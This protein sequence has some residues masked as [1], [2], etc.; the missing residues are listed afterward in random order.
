[1]AA[2]GERGGLFGFSPVVLVLIALMLAV[3]LPPIVFLLASSLH[4]TNPDGSFRDFTFRFYEQLVT[5]PRFGRNLSNTTI[6][7]CGSAVVA[8]V[9]GTIQAWIVERT[10]TPL[11]Q[12]VFL[13]S[14]IALGIPSVLYTVAFLLLLGKAG[15]VNQF[16]A[17][18]FGIQQAISVYTMWGMI[19]VE[20]IDFAPLVFLLMAAVFRSADASFEE[21]SFMSGA[22]IG[23]TF[24]HVTLRLAIPGL[25]A[26]LILIFIR[27]FESFET[28]ALVGRPGN[29]QVLT[30]DIFRATQ[31]ESPPN[32][33]QAG[34]FSVALLT[35]VMIL[36]YWYNRLS[37][38]AERY[39]TITGKGF[40]PRVISLGKWRYLTAA[41]LILLFIV[42][43]V[44]PLVI[45]IWAAFLPF[46]QP[47]TMK[48]LDF[49]TTENFHGMIDTDVLRHTLTNTL[50]L[51]A[52]TATT[53]SLLSAVFAWLAVRRYRGAWILDQLATMPLIFPSIVM[54]V[55]L[56]QVFL[57]AP[58]PIYGTMLSLILAS[59]LRFL[60]YGMRYSYAGVLQIH[61]DL[62]QASLIS[63]ARQ[64]TTFVRIVLP[65]V[66]PALVTSWLFVFLTST[67]AV[68]LLLLLTGPDTR[69]V[70]VMIFDLWA[71][72][73]LP[74]LA[75]LGV[76]WTAFMTVVSAIFYMVARRYGVTAR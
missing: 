52:G 48:A 43:I 3:M 12:Y 50:I 63:G 10:D 72:G 73:S 4:T 53:V 51:G 11:R 75:A 1:V 7:A 9:L 24:R 62:E 44:A 47:F 8:I 2:R 38:H 68:S 17:D 76:T 70:A 67:K 19:I 6:Y 56:L 34:A 64:G 61:T 29:I 55:A 31:I 39:Q 28:P 26:L 32:F 74:K 18:V 22:G 36:L 30:T 35:I 46:Y 66:L 40:R 20:G 13:V 69:V 42:I 57:T 71:D 41:I 14:I 5:N 21:A 33:G 23:Q 25:A 37:R 49:L 65:L 60:P 15:P 16:F 27:A 59:A 54:G 58:F 45:V